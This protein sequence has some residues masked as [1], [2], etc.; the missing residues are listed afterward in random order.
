[1]G[2]AVQWLNLLSWLQ[3]PPDTREFGLQAEGDE[4]PTLG[5]EVRTRT[6]H[7]TSTGTECTGGGMYL[8]QNLYMAKYTRVS[9]VLQH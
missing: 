7:C 9:N 3:F 6:L 5:L 2:E 8:G 4:D 1:M